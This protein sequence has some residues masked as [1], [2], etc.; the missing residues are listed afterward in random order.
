MDVSFSG[1]PQSFRYQ[2]RLVDEKK[3]GWLVSLTILELS[4]SAP[5]SGR[6]QPRIRRNGAKW[7]NKG[8]NVS[9]RNVSLQRKSGLDYGT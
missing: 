9:W 6:L 8:R 7:R 2:H 5:T 3:S 4:V 1:L